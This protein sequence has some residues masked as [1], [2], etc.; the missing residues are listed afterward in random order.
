MATKFLGNAKVA[1]DAAASGR[2]TAGANM[3]L[4]VLEDLL[5]RYEYSAW[6]SDIN[7]IKMGILR[8]VK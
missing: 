1:A 4:T 6:T 2:G 8:S 5:E 7:K 3:K